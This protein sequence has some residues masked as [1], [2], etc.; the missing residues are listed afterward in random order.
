M[1]KFLKTELFTSKGAVGLETIQPKS[2]QS[3]KGYTIWKPGA[4]LLYAA[5]AV[6]ERKYDWEHKVALA[7]SPLEVA[8]ILNVNV[9][10]FPLPKSKDGKT[11]RLSFFHDKGKGGADEGK[12]VKSLTIQPQ[13]STAVPGTKAY[14]F[15]FTQRKEGQE[16]KANVYLNYVQ[17]AGLQLDLRMAYESVKVVDAQ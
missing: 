5:N 1:K 15:F 4:V 13:D 7:L 9:P 14:G 6:A 8:Q 16:T 11:E 12:D 2:E 3:D 10:G 17:F